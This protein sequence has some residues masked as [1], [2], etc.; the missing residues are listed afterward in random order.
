MED[1]LYDLGN[2]FDEN[3]FINFDGV[4]IEMDCLKM[5]YEDLGSSFVF[6]M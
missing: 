6:E 4:E 1:G 5:F 3:F 2:E